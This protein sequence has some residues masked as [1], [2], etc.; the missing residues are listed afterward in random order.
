[1]NKKPRVKAVGR[2][3]RTHS[4][5]KSKKPQAKAKGAG[6]MGG[7]VAPSLSDQEFLKKIDPV[8]LRSFVR[9]LLRVENDW[10]DVLKFDVDRMPS[11]A[12]KLTRKLLVLTGGTVTRPEMMSCRAFGKTLGEK[13]CLTKGLE[14][15]CRRMETADDATRAK[16][17]EML[18]GPKGVV[19]LK[20][21]RVVARRIEE[22]KTAVLKRVKRLTIWDQ[23]HFY[24]GYGEGLLLG[25]RLNRW[26]SGASVREQHQGYMIGV[27]VVF[28]EVIEILCKNGGWTAV[29]EFFSAALL[30]TVAT[31]ISEDAFVKMLQRAGLRSS[32]RGGRPKKT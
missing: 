20:K 17:T 18:G 25:R 24:S 10:D 29:R 27:A 31:E 32:V 11:W 4:E 30:D 12:V 26:K 1:M 3:T 2:T 9:R 14:I 21:Q 7:E 6:G 19:L 15:F 13:V 8:W 16:L 5:P 28:W 22:I 23:G